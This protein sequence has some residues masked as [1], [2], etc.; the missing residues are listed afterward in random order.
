MTTEQLALV[1]DYLLKRRPHGCGELVDWL[2]QRGWQMT[3][4]ELE[5]ERARRAA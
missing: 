3:L 4:A 5:A 2:Y 1:P